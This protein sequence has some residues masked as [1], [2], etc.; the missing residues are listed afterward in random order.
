MLGYSI[1][2]DSPERFFIRSSRS[3]RILVVMLLVI[4]AGVVLPPFMNGFDEGSLLVSI[5]VLPVFVMLFAIVSATIP[6]SISIHKAG[7]VIER[8]W[9]GRF[10]RSVVVPKGEIA[11]AKVLMRRYY[12]ISIFYHASIELKDANGTRR[13]IFSAAHYSLAL[14]RADINLVA[15]KLR[16]VLA[17]QV[18]DDILSR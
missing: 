11:S 2:E 9:L 17:L 12:P 10:L 14:V 16:N 4:C 5:L 18:N 13:A 6:Y 8:K 15:S 3:K 7:I 1:L